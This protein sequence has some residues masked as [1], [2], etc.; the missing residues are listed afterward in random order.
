MGRRALLGGRRGEAEVETWD[1]QKGGREDGAWGVPSPHACRL[2]SSGPPWPCGGLCGK[3]RERQAPH[4]PQPPSPPPLPPDTLT[5]EPYGP[6][7]ATR[8]H[9]GAPLPQRQAVD[10][11]CVA[12]E[13]PLQGEGS[14]RTRSRK[15]PPPSPPAASPPSHSSSTA[16]GEGP[17]L[18][19]HRVQLTVST[20]QDEGILLQ[21]K[22]RAGHGR[23]GSEVSVTSGQGRVRIK[24]G[25][26]TGQGRALIIK[27][28]NLGDEK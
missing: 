9:L 21:K 27:G 17:R 20:R 26:R 11:V 13:G 28:S 2:R 15:R 25:P 8:E 18:K 23:V 12:A 16:H 5:P 1:A 4:L 19:V 6:I 10:V 3:S 7:L 14:V 24:S 22:A